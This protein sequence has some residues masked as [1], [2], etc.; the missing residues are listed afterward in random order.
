MLGVRALPLGQLRQL[1]LLNVEEKTWRSVA[2]SGM[3][4]ACREGRVHLV[5]AR[6]DLGMAE[7]E[8]DYDEE[9][10]EDDVR[11]L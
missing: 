3:E 9:H 6:G 2:M 8:D 1:T 4:E 11:M 7:K 10:A 5:K